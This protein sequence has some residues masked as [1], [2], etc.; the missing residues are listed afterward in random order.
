ML[1]PRLPTLFLAPL[2]AC[3]LLLAV[4]APASAENPLDQFA[5][6]VGDPPV[7][8]TPVIDGAWGCEDIND[9]GR[10][11]LHIDCDRS[12]TCV[13]QAGSWVCVSS[14]RNTCVNYLV[15]TPIGV[16]NSGGGCV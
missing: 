9:I 11:I 2:L 16:T 13:S 15:V 5:T 14:Y 10:E 4:A 6:P 1:S 8:G 3:G 12:A 7:A